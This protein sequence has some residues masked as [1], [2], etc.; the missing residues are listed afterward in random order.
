MQAAAEERL[1]GPQKQ[2]RTRVNLSSSQRSGR[3]RW[4]HSG[5]TVPNLAQPSSHHRSDERHRTLRSR[6]HEG[7]IQ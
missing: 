7:R 1:E 6:D 5:S 4:S 2:N 3:H